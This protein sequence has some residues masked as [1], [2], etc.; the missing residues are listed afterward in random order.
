MIREHHAVHLYARLYTR[1]SVYQELGFGVNRSGA[2]ELSFRTVGYS[3]RSSSAV[4]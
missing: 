3:S 4:V 1:Q 2:Q